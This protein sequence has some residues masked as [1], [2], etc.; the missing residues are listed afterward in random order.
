MDIQE[1]NEILSNYNKLLTLAKEK[2]EII[3]KLD[4]KYCTS[5]G[6]E[7]ILFDDGLVIVKCDDN[8]CGLY[9]SYYF[10]FPILWLSKSDSELR[11][12]IITERELK[13]EKERKDKEEKKLL[14]KIQSEQREFLLYEKLKSKFEKE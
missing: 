9:D 4:D 1:I 14:K 3:E 13:K 7:E 11:E 12:I 8:S 10:D 2:I 5:N 6:I